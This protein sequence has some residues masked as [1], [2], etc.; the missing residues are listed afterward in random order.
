MQENIS[1][2]NEKSVLTIVPGVPMKCTN[3]DFRYNAEK[4]EISVTLLTKP[5][6]FAQTYV[7][8]IHHLA[9]LMKEINAS[10]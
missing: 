2:R 5:K 9:R 6:D 8:E 3:L 7:K 10:A 4:K 1:P